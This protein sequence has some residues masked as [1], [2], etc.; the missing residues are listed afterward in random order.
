MIGLPFLALLFIGA[1]VW[2]VYWA[3]IEPGFAFVGPVC[4]LIALILAACP[5]VGYYP[6]DA[7]YH[8]WETV[9]GQVEKVSSRFLGDGKSTT[10]R[11]VVRFADGRERSCDDTRCSLVKV[12]DSLA[13]SCKKHWQYAGQAGW[14]CNYSGR[15][16]AT[17]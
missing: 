9:Q 3:R 14:D 1:V 16:E 11:F 12:G 10:Q 8:R 4:F 2:F 6:Y 17:R 5:V 13:L 7:Q 15:N